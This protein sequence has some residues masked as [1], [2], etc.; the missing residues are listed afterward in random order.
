MS[1]GYQGLTNSEYRALCADLRIK[2]G[3]DFVVRRA[4]WNELSAKERTNAL[5]N[6]RSA[7]PGVRDPIAFIRVFPHRMSTYKAELRRTA[8]VVSGTTASLTQ[9]RPAAGPAPSA[10]DANS[11]GSDA[12][13]HLM[14]IHAGSS[15]CAG[16]ILAGDMSHTQPEQPTCSQQE[17]AFARTR[18]NDSIGSGAHR[19]GQHEGFTVPGSPEASN[20]IEEGDSGRDDYVIE[21]I[22]ENCMLA[23]LTDTLTHRIAEVQAAFD[24][25]EEQHQREVDALRNEKTA[26][27]KTIVPM[28]RT[29]AE[30]Q[31]TNRELEIW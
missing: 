26:L 11:A 20:E 28:G 17:L 10:G 9:V 31:I 23:D 7:Y 30:G 15:T 19:S 4:T 12:N 8:T 25:R 21:L 24:A 29:A 2:S 16:N 14:I 1:L 3:L 13:G 6:L 22:S 5:D 27:E 18:V